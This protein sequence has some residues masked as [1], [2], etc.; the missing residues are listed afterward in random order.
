[1]VDEPPSEDEL[2]ESHDIYAICGD[3]VY[4]DKADMSVDI[5]HQVAKDY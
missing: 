3:I 4:L 1:M 2:D 5:I